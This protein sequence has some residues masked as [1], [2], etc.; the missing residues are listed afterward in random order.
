MCGQG[1]ILG[2]GHIGGPGRWCAI[3]GGAVVRQGGKQKG[4]LADERGGRRWRWRRRP[5]GKQREGRQRL[6]S[7]TGWQYEG[8][9][10]REEEDE[11][12]V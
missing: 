9:G 2:P 4:W 6:T 8:G 5:Q 1:R 12:V 10:S 3:R 7:K 11:G